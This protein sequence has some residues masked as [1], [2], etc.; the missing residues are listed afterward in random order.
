M[1]EDFSECEFIESEMKFYT[2]NDFCKN[3]KAICR[4][5]LS[6]SKNGR[7][8]YKYYVY[9]NTHMKLNFKNRIWDYLN[10]YCNE[11]ELLKLEAL[12]KAS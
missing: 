9:A 8:F 2:Y 5:F 3:R 10:G 4:L 11:E 7:V 1:V 12:Y 6:L